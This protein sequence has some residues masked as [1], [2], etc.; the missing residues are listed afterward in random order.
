M[1]LEASHPRIL[2][3]YARSDG[4]DIAAELR[5]QLEKKFA[6]WQ[7]LADM[8]GG[9]DWWRQITSAIDHIEYVVLVM[10]PNALNPRWC[11]TNGAMPASRAPA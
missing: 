9:K 6:I 4:K 8:E 1:P 10:T 7:D 3:S 11:A 2:I 5:H